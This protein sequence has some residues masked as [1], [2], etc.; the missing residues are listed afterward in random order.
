MDLS[1][2]Y[3]ICTPEVAH[4]T[5]DGEAVIVNLDNGYYY[6]L[7]EVGAE[8]WNLIDIG[9]T[10]E[11]V[12][13]IMEKRYSGD[14]GN[15]GK[16]LEGL[17]EILFDEKLIEPSADQTAP[18]I[19][20]LAGNLLVGEELGDFN[21]PVLEKYDDMQQLLLLDPIHEVDEEGWPHQLEDL[22]EESG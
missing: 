11:Q 15:I 1:T 13:E 7:R 2:P 6:S 21:L 8:V 20:Q 22:E 12:V 5:I 17:F 16:T 19:E 18:S 10:P 9:A 14:S 3:R 4:E